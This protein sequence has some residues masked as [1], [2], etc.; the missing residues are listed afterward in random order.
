MSVTIYHNPRCR[1]SR[2]TL[3]LLEK[4]GVKPRIIEYLTT[5]PDAAMLEKLLKKLGLGPRDILRKKEA[6]DAGLDNPALSD[7]Q[8]IAKMA[9]N[10]IVIERPIVV[11]PKGARLCRPPERVR[12]IL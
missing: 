4:A 11:T 5:P 8:L 1:K 12:E 3:A 6:Q 10:P 7:K 9:K 2:E